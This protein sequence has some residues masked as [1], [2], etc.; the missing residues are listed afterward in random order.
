MLGVALTAKRARVSVA[1]GGSVSSWSR[2]YDGRVLGVI[3]RRIDE[4]RGVWRNFRQHRL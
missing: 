1:L 2:A 4:S 3:E